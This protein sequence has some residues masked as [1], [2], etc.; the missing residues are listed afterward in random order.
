MNEALLVQNLEE[1]LLS[2][3]MKQ[4]EQWSMLSNEIQY[5]Q[6]NQHPIV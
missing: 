3:S 5:V 4:I 2:T 1:S 6:Y